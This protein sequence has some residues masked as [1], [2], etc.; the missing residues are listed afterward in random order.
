MLLRF[1]LHQDQAATAIE[2]AVY[3]TL[4]DDIR[5]RDIAGTSSTGVN[6]S[7]MGNAVAERI[8]VE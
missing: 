4:A 3:A 1:S 5:T 7:E 2:K 8:F 6:T